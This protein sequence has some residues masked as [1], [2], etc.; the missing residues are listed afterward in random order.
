M[1][2]AGWQNEDTMSATHVDKSEHDVVSVVTPACPSDSDEAKTFFQNFKEGR[3]KL[4]GKQYLQVNSQMSN[5]E[6]KYV[7]GSKDIF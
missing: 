2:I 7:I 3:S 1:P 4:R 6:W 5:G